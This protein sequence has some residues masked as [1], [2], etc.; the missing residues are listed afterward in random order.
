[1]K[2]L[3]WPLGL[4][5]CVMGCFGALARWLQNLRAFE[6]DT[7]LLIPGAA[8]TAAVTA[9]CVFTALALLVL[10]RLCAETRLRPLSGRSPLWLG[11]SVLAGVLTAL[12]AI[13]CFFAAAGERYALLF[14]ILAVLM[15]LSGVSAPMVV[16]SLRRR[17]SDGLS[18]LCAAVPVVFA[19]FWLIVYYK[20]NSSDPTLWHFVIALLAIAAVTLGLYFA[21][22]FVF[23]KRKTS[24]TLYFLNL[25]TFLC[26]V[27]LADDHS[28]WETLLFLGLILLQLS[29]SA[30]ITGQERSEE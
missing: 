17:E 8:G 14:R 18:C 19:C 28:R 13:I 3:H 7:G 10:T 24:P 26:I 29:L 20:L 25:G 22:G 23:G 21:A 16:R 5:S 6:A 27:T 11:A 12:A 15:L 1:M 30:L 9:L 4:F 2:K